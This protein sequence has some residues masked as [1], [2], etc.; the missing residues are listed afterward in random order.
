MKHILLLTKSIA[1]LMTAL[2]T[3]RVKLSLKTGVVKENFYERDGF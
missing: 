2:K 3:K 1:L